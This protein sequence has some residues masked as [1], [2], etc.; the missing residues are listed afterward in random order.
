MRCAAHG[1]RAPRQFKPHEHQVSVDQLAKI[2]PHMLTHTLS[3]GNTRDNDAPQK[4][5][6]ARPQTEVRG[7]KYP[8]LLTD[9]LLGCH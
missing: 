6:D 9:D 4:P 2:Q 5:R 1:F 8:L 3:D 7:P